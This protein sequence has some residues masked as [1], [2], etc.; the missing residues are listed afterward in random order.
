MLTK[1]EG[2]FV[3]IAVAGHEDLLLNRGEKLRPPAR[4]NRLGQDALYL[5]P[6]EEAARVAIGEYVRP[7][8]PP[9]LLLRYHVAA[10]DLLDLRLPENAAL[11]ELAK[12]PWQPPHRAG[13]APPSWGAADEIRQRGIKGLI[14]PSRRRP[15]LWHI[16]L[17]NWNAADAPNVTRV[18][19]AVPI[20]LALDYR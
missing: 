7:D 16:T 2:E 10:C 15:G 6:H 19:R 20:K 8:D 14:D 4:F 9:R 11:Y 17:F 5:S 18:G 3:K 12:Q 1:I 13:K